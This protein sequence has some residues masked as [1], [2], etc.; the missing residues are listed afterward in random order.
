[1]ADMPGM[2][3]CRSRPRRAACDRSGRGGATRYQFARASERPVATTVRAV[4]VLKYAEPRQAYVNA[5]VSGWVE[6]LYADYVG[7]R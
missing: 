1:M 6:K 7:K 3:A 2:G 5:R 4:G